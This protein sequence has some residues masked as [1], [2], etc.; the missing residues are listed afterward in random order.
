MGSFWVEMAL[1]IIFAVLKQV[2][3]NPTH[4]AEL[5]RA[6]EKLRDTLLV[7]YPVETA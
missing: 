5:R 4:K 2:V 7:V 1:S 6:M 3:K